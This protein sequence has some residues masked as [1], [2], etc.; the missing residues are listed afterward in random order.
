MMKN[1]AS[2]SAPSSNSSSGEP[3]VGFMPDTPNSIGPL[4]S[5]KMPGSGAAAGAPPSSRRR[6]SPPTLPAGF[7]SPPSPPQALEPK[8]KG[9]KGGVGQGNGTPTDLCQSCLREGVARG[10]T[11]WH[12]E[13]SRSTGGIC[14]EHA[15]Q[16]HTEDAA[17]FA[18]NYRMRHG[19]ACE[20]CGILRRATH[21]LLSE[22]ISRFCGECAAG[23]Y[24]VVDLNNFK[25]RLGGCNR[26]ARY[27]GEAS[28]GTVA[29]QLA[30]NVRQ[31]C[32]GVLVFRCWVHKEP[33]M[34][35]AGEPWRDFYR[36][37]EETRLA[38]AVANG[39]PHPLLQQQ[40][41]KK[42]PPLVLPVAPLVPPSEALPQ[43]ASVETL[44]PQ[45]PNTVA[46]N[47]ALPTPLFPPAESGAAMAVCGA[48]VVSPAAPGPLL[49]VLTSMDTQDGEERPLPLHTHYTNTPTT[50]T[51]DE[52]GV[53]LASGN[54][55]GFVQAEGG[56]VFS[57]EVGGAEGE[58][59][60][61]DE[62]HARKKQRLP[63]PRSQQPH[64]PMA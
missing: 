15:H 53:P 9:K 17:A 23:E 13:Q 24:N 46:P 52:T 16:L 26:M 45:L 34:K 25:C 48:V 41:G 38:E 61:G 5:F 18:R 11:H 8:P 22:G 10:I 19:R 29:T 2:S 63:H 55:E 27:I 54:S 49:P 58:E 60:E 51:L 14:R 33:D 35:E 1:V 31:D 20:K 42:G 37:F 44:L 32:G 12:K 62:G 57:V 7:V 30:G 3:T 40:H 6:S 47:A 43:P 50:H 36:H 21:G 59:G 64:L 56:G 39:L 4:S 28:P